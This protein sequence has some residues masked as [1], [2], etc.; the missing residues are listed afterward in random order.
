MKIGVFLVSLALLAAPA[1]AGH[2]ASEETKAKPAA[3]L[4][5]PTSLRGSI[6][7][8]RP[9]QPIAL[10]SPTPKPPVAAPITP[11]AS[12]APNTGQCRASCAHTYYFCLSGPVTT[13][14]AETWSQ[15]SVSCAHPPLTI[16]H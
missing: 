4:K 12:A 7:P 15:C 5:L 10:V 13:D 16:E 14:C 2:A 9:R 8:Q 3:K 1:L 11:L 6:Q